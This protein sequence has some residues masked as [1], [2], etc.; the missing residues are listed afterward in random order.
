MP[1]PPTRAPPPLQESA[2]PQQQQPKRQVVAQ[3]R[4]DVLAQP[5][6]QQ[7]QQQQQQ[8]PGLAGWWDRL[9]ESM[10]V[11]VRLVVIFAVLVLGLL[12]NSK[13]RALRRKI[14]PVK[15][16]YILQ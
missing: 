2:L 5:F 13:P 10:A 8:R 6:A 4:A 12:S 7:E 14:R 9:R 16:Y 3:R 11:A 1:P 15:Q